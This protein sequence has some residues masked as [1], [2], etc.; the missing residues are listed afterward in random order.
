M[1]IINQLENDIS[2]NSEEESLKTR[3]MLE[4][5]IEKLKNKVIPDSYEIISSKLLNVFEYR[6]LIIQLSSYSLISKNW[7]NLLVKWIGNRKCLEVMAGRGVLSKALK[8]CGVNIIPT[9][10]FAWN[11]MKQNLWMDIEQIDA[12]SAV[13]KYGKN[14]DLILCSWPYTDNAAYE[15]IRTMYEINKNLKMIYIGEGYNGC[16]AND[17]FFDSV[18]E[19]NNS[20]FYHIN[21]FYTSFPFI[22][23]RIKLLKP[24]KR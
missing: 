23:D 16:C 12:V 21:Q 9:D 10:S 6:D 4:N 2:Q 20:E 7:I 24:L 11:N 17:K 15:I 22:N 19:I 8:N 18:A 1:K 13:K 14:V 5:N 3:K